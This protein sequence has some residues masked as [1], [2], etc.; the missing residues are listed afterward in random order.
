MTKAK[1]SYQFFLGIW[2]AEYHVVVLPVPKRG[3][4]AT[5]LW[6]WRSSM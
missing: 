5:T 3:R 1:A 4:E 2:Y 6:Y